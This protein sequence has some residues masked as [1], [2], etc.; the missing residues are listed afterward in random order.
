MANYLKISTIEIPFKALDESIS[1][2]DAVTE[3]MK[4]LKSHIDRVLPDKPDLIVIPEACDR[5]SN[6]KIERYREYYDIRGNR[7]A[8][9]FQEPMTALNPLM[10]VGRQI[11]EVLEIHTDLKPRARKA[12]VL[13]LVKDVHLPDPERIVNS[14]PHQLSG[15]QRQ[16]IVI[17][18]ALAL[19]LTAR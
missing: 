6:Y 3:M 7:I 17:A 1:D 19:A 10:M 18:M 11:D 4:Y 5:P 14:Y 8:M 2:E 15:G 16:R 9:I 13:E 12:R